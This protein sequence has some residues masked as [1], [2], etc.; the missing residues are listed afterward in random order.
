[1]D[2]KKVCRCCGCRLFNRQR[3]SLYC[4][5]CA[6]DAERVRSTLYR[7][8]LRSKLLRRLN[9]RYIFKFRLERR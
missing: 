6:Y 9:K 3:H 5:D 2:R 4:R 1:M 7:C 8:I